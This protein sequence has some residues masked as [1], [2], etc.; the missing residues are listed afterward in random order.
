MAAASWQRNKEKVYAYRKERRKRDPN[1][2]ISGNL[3][4]YIYQRVGM[5]ND[6]G[7]SRFREVVGCTID[8]FR[9][10]LE[11][12]WQPGMNWENYGKLDGKWSIDHTRPCSRFD[13]TDPEQ[14]RACFHFSNMKPMWWRDNL[15]KSDKIATD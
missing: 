8:E 4:T 15:M 1:Y 2:H 3:R 13:L 10:H 12:H 6:T 9:K 14:V 11:A 7:Q 5:K